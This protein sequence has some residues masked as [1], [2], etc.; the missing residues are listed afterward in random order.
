MQSVIY[1]NTSISYPV[2]SKRNWHWFSYLS[3]HSIIS[4]NHGSPIVI[5]ARPSVVKDTENCVQNFLEADLIKHARHQTNW[6]ST[7]NPAPVIQLTSTAVGL[8]LFPSPALEVPPL[9]QGQHWR[10]QKKQKAHW[11]KAHI[12]SSGLQSSGLGHLWLSEDACMFK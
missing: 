9:L 7:Q 4:G 3:F 10:T 5:A 2:S 11:H 8:L 6:Q 12:W 1:K